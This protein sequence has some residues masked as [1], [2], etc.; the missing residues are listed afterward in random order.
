MLPQEIIRIKSDGGILSAHEIDVS[1]LMIATI[2]GLFI[3]WG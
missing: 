1:N 3:G 2:A